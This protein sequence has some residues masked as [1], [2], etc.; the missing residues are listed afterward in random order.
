MAS[1]GIEF[2][3]VGHTVYIYRYVA[4]AISSNNTVDVRLFIKRIRVYHFHS[5]SLS[6]RNAV[7][8]SLH[9]IELVQS[10]SHVFAV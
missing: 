2:S 7:G 9:R 8:T 5:Y 1:T 10:E 4:Q 3:D 6:A